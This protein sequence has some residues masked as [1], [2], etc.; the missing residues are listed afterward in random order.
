MRKSNEFGTGFFVLVAI[1]LGA[2]ACSG[3]TP[4]PEKQ[5]NPVMKTVSAPPAPVDEPPYCAMTPEV[6]KTIVNGMTRDQVEKIMG[7]QTGEGWGGR[8]WR[9]LQWWS[10]D[11]KYRYSVRMSKDYIVTGK[12]SYGSL[13]LNYLW[14]DDKD[15]LRQKYERDY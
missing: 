9:E 6:F 5:P 1:I 14:K 7:C 15:K 8:T 10:V 4:D 11:W 13:Y 2:K 12:W 3:P